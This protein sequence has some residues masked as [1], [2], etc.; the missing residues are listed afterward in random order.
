MKTQRSTMWGCVAAAGFTLSIGCGQEGQS[1]DS[2]PTA[3]LYSLEL[4]PEHSVEFYEFAPGL[5]GVGEVM[6][7]DSGETLVTPSLWEEGLNLAEVFSQLSSVPIPAS[8]LEAERRRVLA[9]DVDLSTLT[10]DDFKTF[11]NI[12]PGTANQGIT[13]KSALPVCSTDELGDNWG[14]EW[15][16]NKFVHVAGFVGGSWA[17]QMKRFNTNPPFTTALVTKAGPA[18]A[19]R[20]HGFA[21]DFLNGASFTVDFFGP[22][23]IT[24]LNTTVAPRNVRIFNSS[25]YSASWNNRSMVYDDCGHGMVSV[26]WK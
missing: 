14:H 7:V 23:V 25:N 4:A 22:S 1:P 20:S 21:G 18:S 15:F 8:L 6:N 19:M 2:Q 12:E 5:T 11:T 3:L 24:A 10:R 26:A 9:G 16:K 17:G 13:Q